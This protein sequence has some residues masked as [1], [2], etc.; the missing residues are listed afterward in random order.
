[1]SPSC[2]EVRR[3]FQGI[4]PSTFGIQLGNRL[5]DDVFHKILSDVTQWKDYS[6][7]RITALMSDLSDKLK[8]DRLK[9]YEHSLDATP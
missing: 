4:F 6:P 1:M 7:G 3:S 9:R 5:K 8:T 2:E